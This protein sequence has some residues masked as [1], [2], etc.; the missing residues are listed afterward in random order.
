MEEVFTCLKQNIKDKPYLKQVNLVFDAMS[1]WKEVLYDHKQGTNIGY[2]SLGNGLNFDG[3]ET[4][5]TEALVFQ[6]VPLKESFKCAVAYFFIDKIS[7]EPLSKL[8][9][10]CIIKLYECGVQVLNVTFDGTS[11][12]TMS[13][14]KNLD[15]TCQK[16][17]SFM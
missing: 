5:A 17:L 16:S 1:I 11:T 13:V 12:N 4:L 6:I 3:Q 15:V 9:K 14:K 10:M 2:V 8:I 7:A